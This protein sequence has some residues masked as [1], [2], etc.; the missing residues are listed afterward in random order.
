M[1]WKTM[2]VREQR[3]QF[4]VAALRREQSLTALC[5]EFDISRPT[6]R[7]WLGRY[8][9]QGIAGIAERSRRPLHSP[10]LTAGELEERVVELR[11]RYPDW[12]ARKLG[13]LLERQGVELTHST[14]HRILLRPDLIHPADRHDVAAEG[15]E[16]PV[17]TSCGTWTSR[18]RRVE[19]GDR[20]VV[21]DRR[22]QPLFAAVAADWEHARGAGPGAVA[23]RVLRLRCP[24]GD[25]DGP[26]HS[27][28]ERAIAW[29][30]LSWRCG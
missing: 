3:V 7:L 14:I 6:G 26:W 25:A 12:G 4:V 1:P 30:P 5:E 13:V 10:R 16:P 23:E 11:R 17:R 22:P 27:V 21:G 9:Q 15:F 28:V 29:E 24:G 19:C 18:A 8:R 20:S 2:D